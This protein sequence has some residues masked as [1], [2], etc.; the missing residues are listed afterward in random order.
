EEWE[1]WEKCPAASAAMAV[2]DNQHIEK[3]RFLTIS[4][5]QVNPNHKKGRASSL[6]TADKPKSAV[7]FCTR[8]WKK[9]GRYGIIEA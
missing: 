5:H 2:T 8:I 4:S 6:Q 1:E 7:F 3:V 9:R